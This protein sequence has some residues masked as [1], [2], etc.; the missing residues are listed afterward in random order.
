MN[1]INKLFDLMGIDINTM[2][3]TGLENMIENMVNNIKE[4]FPDTHIPESFWDKYRKNPDTESLRKLLAA[5]YER[6]YTQE[7]IAGLIKFYESP[8]GRK[9]VQANAQITQE[10]QANAIAY[11][12][13]LVQE[14]VKELIEEEYS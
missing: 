12:E 2:A 10:S 11:Y 4:K 14:V 5:I 7:E 8:L 1:E 9:S 6:H 13:S 3:S